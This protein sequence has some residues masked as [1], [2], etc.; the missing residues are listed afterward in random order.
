ML[1]EGQAADLA[2]ALIDAAR[3]AGA[4]SADAMIG[5]SR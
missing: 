4:S 5:I 3:K 1:N 2:A